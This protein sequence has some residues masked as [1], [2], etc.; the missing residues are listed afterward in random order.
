MNGGNLPDHLDS[1]AADRKP[2]IDIEQGELKSTDDQVFRDRSR[3]LLRRLSDQSILNDDELS[4]VDPVVG[5]VDEYPGI[6]Y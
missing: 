1:T 3:L 4:D 5:N 2:S 6:G